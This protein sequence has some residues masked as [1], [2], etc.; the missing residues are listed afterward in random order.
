MLLGVQSK[1]R[2]RT[3]LEND[4]KAMDKSVYNMRLPTEGHVIW[5]EKWEKPTTPPEEIEDWLDDIVS[6]GVWIA[7]TVQQEDRCFVLKVA[8]RS[9][10]AKEIIDIPTTQA[11]SDKFT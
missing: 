5:L 11:T 9:E 6:C 10:D 2:A 8:V 1:L 4:A 7:N 3:K